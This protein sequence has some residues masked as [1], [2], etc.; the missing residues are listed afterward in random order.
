MILYISNLGKQV[1]EESLRA[2]FAAHGEVSS[3]SLTLDATNEHGGIASLEMPHA[4]EALLAMDHI[5]GCVMDGKAIRVSG[6]EDHSASK[7][8]IVTSLKQPL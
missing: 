2:T 5:D 8:N 3:A 4:G 7:Q 1:T 6:E